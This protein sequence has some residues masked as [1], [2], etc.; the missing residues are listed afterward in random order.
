MRVEDVKVG[1]KLLEQGSSAFKTPATVTALTDLGFKYKYDEDVDLGPRYGYI[2]KD[3][4]CD[5]Y[6]INGEFIF[7]EALGEK[8]E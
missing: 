8:V 6:H 3:S 5:A 7:W 2:S 1:M 4:E